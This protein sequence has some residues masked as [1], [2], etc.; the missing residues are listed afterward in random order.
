[1]ATNTT[2]ILGKRAAGASDMPVSNAL[3]DAQEVKSVTGTAANSGLTVSADDQFW[4]VT[5][6]DADI[7]VLER[8]A[9]SGSDVTTTT[10]WLV[11]SGTRFE[12]KAT[13][14]STLSLILDA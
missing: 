2:I 7:R 13:N 8:V 9:G 12:A 5:P 1:M 6:K 3:Y 11:K 10:G 4:F 14:G